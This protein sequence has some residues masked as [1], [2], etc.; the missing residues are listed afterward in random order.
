MRR[1]S[2]TRK[3]LGQAALEIGQR[4]SA[5]RTF[6]QLPLPRQ[7]SRRQP[8]GPEHVVHRAAD[9]HETPAATL[10]RLRPGLGRDF[11]VVEHPA[12][13]LDRLGTNQLSVVRQVVHADNQEVTHRAYPAPA[14]FAGRQLKRTKER[15]LLAGVNGLGSWNRQARLYHRPPL[16]QTRPSATELPNWVES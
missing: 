5:T 4:V 1:S 14:R 11:L 6:G 12:R 16:W 3:A 15:P 8:K 13:V 10:G 9:E 7:R 2:S